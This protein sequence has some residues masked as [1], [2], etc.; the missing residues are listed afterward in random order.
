MVEVARRHGDYALVGLATKIELDGD[1][2]TDAALAFFGAASVPTRVAEAEQLLVGERHS[3][4]LF[5]A[6]SKIVSSTLSPPGDVHGTT[7]YR[8]HLAGVLARNGLAAAIAK[9]GV[10]A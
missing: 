7:A 9:I 6:A 2:I 10:S 3:P 1:V 5:S 4:E 8:K